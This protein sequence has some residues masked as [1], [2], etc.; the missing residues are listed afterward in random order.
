M[1]IETPTGRGIGRHRIVPPLDRRTG[2]ETEEEV[3]E[4][5]TDLVRRVRE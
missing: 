4:G 3:Q 5:E 1:P 2:E